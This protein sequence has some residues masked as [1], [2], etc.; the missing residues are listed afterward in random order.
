MAGGSAAIYNDWNTYLD[1]GIALRP[2]ELAGRGRRINDP[3]YA[4]LDEA[5]E[6]VFQRIKPEIQLAPYLIFG[7]SMGCRMAYKLVQKIRA[8]KLPMPLHTFFSGGSAPHLHREDKKIFHVMDDEEF[9]RELLNLGGTPPQFLEYP[10]LLEIFLPVL[11]NDFRIIETHQYDE[12]IY[13][14]ED[15]IT[16]FMGKEDEFTPAQCD[17][18]KYHT[19]GLCHM[20]Y[21]EGGHFFLNN[22]PQQL[23]ELVNRRLELIRLKV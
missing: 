2:V 23:L 21:F 10:E 1:A 13:P 5:V 6:D 3:F 9:G 4:D 20:H 14:L 8:A 7:H 12:K 11:K 22:H 18:W 17:G 15:D 16:V 19:T